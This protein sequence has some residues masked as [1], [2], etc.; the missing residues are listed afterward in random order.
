[1]KTLLSQVKQIL[2]IQRSMPVQ[3]GKN[4][5]VFS[6]LGFERQEV[7]VHCRMLYEILNPSG[8]HGCGDIFLKSFFERVLRKPYPK[9]GATIRREASIGRTSGISGRIDLL[10]EG[11]DICYP[12][13]V[14]VDAPDQPA[15]IA[16]YDS[17]AKKR[18]RESQVFYLTLDGSEPSEDSTGGD[19]NLA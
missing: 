19:S 3:P 12:I 17:F 5:N 15:Q 9:G 4:F 1:M 8:S 14:K 11:S 2:E 10:I 18:A 7:N 13:E 6:L 16:R